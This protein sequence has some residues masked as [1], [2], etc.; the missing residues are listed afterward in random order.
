MITMIV[1][2][3][4]IRAINFFIN[5]PVFSKQNLIILLKSVFG[6]PGENFVERIISL[7]EFT[8]KDT[9]VTKKKNNRLKTRR[10]D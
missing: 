5:S 3:T 6:K 4:M 9:E 2:P 7:K 8:T 10:K 1:M